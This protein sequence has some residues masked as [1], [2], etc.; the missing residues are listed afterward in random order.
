MLTRR[1][2]TYHISQQ[3]IDALWNDSVEDRNDNMEN[4]G[5]LHYMLTDVLARYN[6]SKGTKAKIRKD[7]VSVLE[8]IIE[9]VLASSK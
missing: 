4:A 6:P 1:P 3:R 5:E 7:I 9:E 8:A 2:M